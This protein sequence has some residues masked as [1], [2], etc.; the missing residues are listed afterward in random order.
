[1][2]L[3]EIAGN[4]VENLLYRIQNTTWPDSMQIVYL[5]I[6]TNNLFSNSVETIVQGINACAELIKHQ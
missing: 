4:K 6:C 5:A 2:I 1:M 3:A